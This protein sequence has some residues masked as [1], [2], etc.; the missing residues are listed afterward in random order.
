[1]LRGQTKEQPNPVAQ[2]QA[3]RAARPNELAAPVDRSTA[4]LEA[5]VA[6]LSQKVASLEAAQSSDVVPEVPS[7]LSREA[8]AEAQKESVDRRMA[9]IA[10]IERTEPRDSEWE[11]QMRRTVS[12][13]VDSPGW[14]RTRMES[15]K[16]WTS[17]CQLDVVHETAEAQ[18]AFPRGFLDQPAEFAELWG[19]RSKDDEGIPHTSLYLVRVGHSV[20]N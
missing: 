7:A 9:A 8:I 14:S 15:L 11:S 1:M 10:S 5:I 13:A 17:M 4:R 12:S 19:V 16:C 18:S 3:P 20:F 2:V 6:T